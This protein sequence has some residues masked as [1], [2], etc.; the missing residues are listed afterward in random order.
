[1]LFRSWR[2]EKAIPFIRTT[3]IYPRL[4]CQQIG[5]VINSGDDAE[6]SSLLW[7]HKLETA[8][9]GPRIRAPWPKIAPVFQ[10]ITE[11]VIYLG[12]TK[13]FLGSFDA[14]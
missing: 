5:K 1:M 14:S 6:Q 11:R 13:C 4:N 2:L 12:V 9:K 10:V 3:Q 7:W 8:S